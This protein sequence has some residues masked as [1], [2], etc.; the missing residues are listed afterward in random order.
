MNFTFDFSELKTIRQDMKQQDIS[1]YPFLFE[2]NGVSTFASLTALSEKEH[3]Q[4]EKAKYALF[5]VFF[6]LRNNTDNSV[7]LY[8]NSFGIIYVNEENFRSFF[9]VRKDF[10]GKGFWTNFCR[11]FLAKAPK[12]CNVSGLNSELYDFRRQMI[13]KRADLDPNNCYR[14]SIIR[15]PLKKNG[16]RRQ[17]NPFRYEIAQEKF[18][19]AT[20]LYGADKSI[21]YRFI[22]D[23]SQEV[24]ED[25]A[26]ERF[27]KNEKK[28]LEG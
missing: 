6:T 10:K 26:I 21:T 3:E 5:H 23:K 15:L 19:K 11:T 16:N 2:Y 8:L 17:R 20:R 22:D 4:S 28:R 14:H 1:T 27:T 25:L 9:H 12:N 24:D 7:D 13:Y 18:P